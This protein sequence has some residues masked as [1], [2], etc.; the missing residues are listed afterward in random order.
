MTLLASYTQG[1][2]RSREREDNF[3]KDRSLNL[4]LA[5]AAL[6]LFVS[7][8]AAALGLDGLAW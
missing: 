4:V 1:I 5:F 8:M 3:G 6:G 2:R 7:I